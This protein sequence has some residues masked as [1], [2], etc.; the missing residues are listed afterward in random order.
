M[1]PLPIKLLTLVFLILGAA[2]YGY[3]KGSAKADLQITNLVAE[4]NQLAVDLERRNTDISNTV[5]TEYV[6]RVNVITEKE[7]V[8]RDLAQNTVPSQYVM[9]NGWVYTHDISAT[10]G[11]ADP[12]RASDESPSGIKD[13]TTLVTIA[14]NYATCERNAE[15]LIQLQR[16]I[17]D[18]RAQ[19]E[20]SNA[21]AG[22]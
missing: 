21:E 3:M 11:D 8:Y 9:S 7:Y 19:I 18:N 10:G 2:G 17:T 16:W 12:T 22:N 20:I 1:I 14:A 5:V 6:D 13:N 4:R 15:Q